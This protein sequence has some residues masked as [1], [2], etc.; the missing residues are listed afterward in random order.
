M[1]KIKKPV[2]LIS[3]ALNSRTEGLGF[4]ATCR[5]FCLSSHTLQSWENKFGRLTEVLKLYSLTH[6]FLSQII[7]GD[8][9]YTR[10]D[11]NKP[12]E[13]SEGWTIMLIERASRFI[14]EFECGKKDKALFSGVLERLAELIKQT[15][16]FTLVTDGE[17]R[18]GNILF[19]LCHEVINSNAG[20]G[21]LTVLQE[22]VLVG[23]KNKGNKK[24]SSKPKYERP[25][26]E[27]P[28]TKHKLENCDIHANHA[29][30]QNAATRRKL[31]P[32]RRRTNTYAKTKTALQ[33]VLDVYWVVHNFIRKHYSTKVVPAVANRI[34]KRGF[35]LEEAFMMQL[36]F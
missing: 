13:E 11:K 31:S 23:L 36:S 3:D 18:Y 16:E 7:E 17:R 2:S 35:T 14:W 24:P 30:G 10:V 22:G 29:E 32:F 34:V 26:P 21:P 27:H 25:Q 15:E 19:E 8:E 9:L 28:R 1:F 12:Q 20:D 33:R 5:T 6:T 4:N